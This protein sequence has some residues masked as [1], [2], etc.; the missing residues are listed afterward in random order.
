MA[1]QRAEELARQKMAAAEAALQ[2]KRQVQVALLREHS[3]AAW[4]MKR[5]GA[6]KTWKK[7]WCVLVRHGGVP[8]PGNPL[9][10]ATSAA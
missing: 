5:G 4:L 10:S 1:E 9:S 2:E 7:R 6:A 3:P 8:N